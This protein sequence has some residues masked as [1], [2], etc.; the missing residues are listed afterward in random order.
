MKQ[1]NILESNDELSNA[2][3]DVTREPHGLDEDIWSEDG[4]VRPEVKKQ[5]LDIAQRA[6]DE[7]E[8]GDAELLDIVIT[9]SITGERWS[10]E[11]DVDLHLM[12]QFSDINSDEEFVESYFKMRARVWNSD[13]DIVIGNHP[14]EIYV[15]DVDAPHYS[16]GIYSLLEDKWIKRE[17]PGEYASYDDV[18]KKSRVLAKDIKRIIRDLKNP[19]WQLIESASK[20]MEKLRDMRSVGL[21]EAGEGSVENLTYKVLRRAGLLEKL[22]DASKMAFDKM[23]EN[24]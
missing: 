12:I 17:E 8:Q 4:Q 22:G 1:I 11:S 2:I 9:G 16:V 18:A 6:Y 13:H 15:Q 23:F 3:R 7:L 14:V 10:K 19:T 20:I 5:L 21:K 24:E